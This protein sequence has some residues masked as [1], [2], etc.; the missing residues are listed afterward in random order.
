MKQGKAD[1]WSFLSGKANLLLLKI[2][3]L[4]QCCLALPRK[5]QMWAHRSSGTQKTYSATL[6]ADQE[7]SDLEAVTKHFNT[8]L[9]VHML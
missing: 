4:A 9:W 2:P 3:V 8:L 7:P 5:L 1:I 6:T